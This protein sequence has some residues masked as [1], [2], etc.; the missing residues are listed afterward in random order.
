[1]SDWPAS[2]CA[3]N[4]SLPLIEAAFSSCTALTDVSPLADCK[5]LQIVTLP[6]NA[7]NFE[8]LRAFTK[9]ERLSFAEDK[10]PAEFWKE[11][12][13]QAWLRTLRESGIAIKSVHRLPDGTWQ[14]DLSNAAI[15]DLTILKGTPISDLN[16][17]ATAVTDLTPLRGM[18]IKKLSV[19]NTKVTDLS[20]LEGMPL[21]Y[22]Q[23]MGTT[24]K[25]LAVLRGM[26]L[27]S[28][29]L[30]G[31]KEIT[32]LSPLADCKEL[33]NITLPPNATNFEFLRAF[34]KLAR[35]GFQQDAKSTWL[36]DKTAAEFWQEYDAKKN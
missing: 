14:V 26:P 21:E 29:R 31:C 11:Y 10:T 9:L 36:A 1:M 22:L 6:P 23:I 17:G 15:D 12:D 7:K 19:V 25:D 18:A 20:P 30:I 33:Q 8:F 3:S 34:P 16:I 24:V 4:I 28:V 32:D 2:T 27:T 35:I 13:A 5:E